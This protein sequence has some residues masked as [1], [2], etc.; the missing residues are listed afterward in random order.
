MPAR[1]FTSRSWS[2]DWESLAHHSL[3]MMILLAD[4]PR[5]EILDGDALPALKLARPI[6]SALAD[7]AIHFDDAFLMDEVEQGFLRDGI[8]DGLPRDV[9]IRRE[10]EDDFVCVLRR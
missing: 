4:N 2:S 8:A 7:D 10:Q 9:V 5:R 1:F 6:R 3:E